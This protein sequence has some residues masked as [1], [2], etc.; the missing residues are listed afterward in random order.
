MHFARPATWR[1]RSKEFAKAHLR[2]VPREVEELRRLA[3]GEA[4]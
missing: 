2:G 3:R 4:P 1:M